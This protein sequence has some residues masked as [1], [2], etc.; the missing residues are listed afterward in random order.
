MAVFF[1]FQDSGLDDYN[2]S[3][4]FVQMGF[5]PGF[6]IQARELTQMQTLLQ[7]QFYAL[8]KKV[9]GDSGVL[10]APLT[11][12]RNSGSA[13]SPSD[14]TVTLNPGHVLIRPQDKDLGYAVYLNST[15]SIDVSTATGQPFVYLQYREVQVNPDGDTFDP[16]DGFAAV[17]VDPTLV[18]NAQVYYN[19]SAPGASIYKIEVLNMGTYVAAEGAVP[20]GIANIIYFAN[21]V[22]Y[23][24]NGTPVPLA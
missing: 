23:F 4:N 5:R 13:G 17:E 9:V 8:A 11:V 19:S 16:Q 15:K 18:D 22:P 6:A 21:H 3:K 12:R 24:L 14:F 10:D 1:E 2:R 20:A 7:A